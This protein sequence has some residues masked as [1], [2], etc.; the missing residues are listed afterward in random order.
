M[1][2][3]AVWLIVDRDLLLRLVQNLRIFFIP[4]FIYAGTIAINFE[5]DGYYVSW[6]LSISHDIRNSL[7]LEK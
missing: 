5:L 6:I 7:K 1:H 3:I 2:P 4:T